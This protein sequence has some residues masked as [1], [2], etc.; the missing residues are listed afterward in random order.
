[1]KRK[2]KKSKNIIVCSDVMMGTLYKDGRYVEKFIGCKET[3]G[4][5]VY[6]Y[7]NFIPFW[8]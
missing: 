5:F 4:F 8:N 6:D 3:M 1:M 7:G 2:R